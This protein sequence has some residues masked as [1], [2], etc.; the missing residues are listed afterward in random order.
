LLGVDVT[1]DLRTWM[2]GNTWQDAVEA[3]RTDDLRE[4]VLRDAQ[5]CFNLWQKH[6]HEWPAHERE[7]ANLTMTAGWAGLR[8]DQKLAE[9]AAA[10]LERVM[11]EARNDI[12]WADGDVAVLSIKALGEHCRANSIPPP[13]STS[14]DDPACEAWENKYGAQFPWVAAMRNYRKANKLREKLRVL[15][16]RIR[17]T[18]GCM[19][20]GMKYFGGHTGRW[21][22]RLRGRWSRFRG[23]GGR[24]QF[25]RRPDIRS[26]QLIKQ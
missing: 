6:A 2:K 7:L 26:C 1:K 3:G 13:P 10:A 4:Y 16:E 17:P 8:I 12:P 21:S 24:C 23:H 5:T 14:E 15:T 18:D 22:R 9:H 19:G 11:W 25:P 20:Y